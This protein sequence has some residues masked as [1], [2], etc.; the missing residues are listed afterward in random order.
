TFHGPNR[1]GEKEQEHLHEAPWIMTGPLLLLGVLSAAGGVINIPE[2]YHGNAWL[3]H[4]LEPITPPSA[5]LLPA[6]QLAPATEWVL[7]GVAVVVALVGILAA[8]RL[9]KPDKLVPA[10]SAP[11]ERGF[12]RLLKNKWYVDEI[13][14]ALIVRPLVW[15]SREV[16]WKQVDQRAIDGAAVNGAARGARALGWAN[17]WLQTGQVGMYVAAFVVGVLLLLWRAIGWCTRPGCSPRCSSGRS[18]PPPW[19]CCSPDG[20]RSTSRS[21]PAWWSSRCRCRCGGPSCRRAACSSWSIAR[22]SARGGS[23]TPSAWTGFRC[24]SSC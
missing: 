8:W 1:T 10:R 14:D 6:V 19:C 9:L 12:A 2:L 5:A 11:E 17:R 22:G 23:T 21:P 15:L 16:L 4:W 7:V 24:F 20:W 3:H 13:Y 18:S